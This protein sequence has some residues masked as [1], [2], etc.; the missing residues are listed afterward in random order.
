MLVAR[1]GQLKMAGPPLTAGGGTSYNSGV[2]LLWK[3][4]VN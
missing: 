3:M 4:L 1:L 2:G